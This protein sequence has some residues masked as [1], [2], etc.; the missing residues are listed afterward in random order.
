MNR[1]KEKFETLKAKN[2]KGFVAY[3]TAGDPRL[4]ITHKLVH[5]FAELGVDFI[6]LGIPFSD[7]L[8]DGVVNQLATM[9][10]LKSG[11]TVQKILDL[12][13]KIRKSSDVPL[14]LFT[15]LNPILQYGLESFAKNAQ[16]A[17]VDGVLTLDL[18]PEEAEDYKRILEKNDLNVIF[19]VTPTSSD[20]RIKK[21]ASMSSG[22]IYCV[23]RTGVTGAQKEMPKDVP[24]II[25]KIR[26]F[27][28]LP[29]AIGFGISKPDQVKRLSQMADA[30]VVGSAIVQQIEENVKHPHLE[31]RVT[32]FVKKLVQAL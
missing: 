31:K 5:S 12:V 21:I 23:S 18:P 29:I 17:G 16:K 19:L 2:K 3:I 27:S 26:Q 24:E 10:A 22:F 4:E 13:K 1:I 6:E 11:T 28:K 8:A 9:R 7:P 30:V 14:I 15:Y 20:E 25:S 32:S